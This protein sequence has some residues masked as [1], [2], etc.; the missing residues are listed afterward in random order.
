MRSLARDLTRFGRAQHIEAEQVDQIFE[1][2]FTTKGA[3]GSGVGLSTV[4]AIV[5][6]GRGCIDVQSEPG[7]GTS[8]I[9][10]LAVD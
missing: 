10:C 7:K 2:F 9:V 5:R 1:P 3:A 8:I 4:Y 6:D